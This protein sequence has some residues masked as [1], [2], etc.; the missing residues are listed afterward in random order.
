MNFKEYAEMLKN[1]PFSETL[2]YVQAVMWFHPELLPLGVISIGEEYPPVIK[3]P[4][5]AINRFGRNVPIIAISKDAFAGRDKLTDIVLPAAVRGIPKGAFKGCTELKRITIPKAVNKICKGTF[6][7][8]RDLEDVYYEGT[9]EEW[10]K[11]DIVH[12]KHEIE[13]G[14]MIPGTPTQEIIS[15]RLLH[16]PGNDALFACNIHFRC[17]LSDLENDSDYERMP[18]D[19]DVTDLYRKK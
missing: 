16:I 17:N 14:A 2:E 15:E 1:V 9:A 6:D 18:T 5:R 11:I 10:E 12:Q 13:L 7:G 3:V 8:C 19:K 4:S